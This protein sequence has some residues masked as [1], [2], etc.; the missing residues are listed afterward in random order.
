MMKNKNKLVW[1]ENRYIVEY[2][3]ATPAIIQ[4]TPITQT[5]NLNIKNSTLDSS[6]FF[7]FTIPIP[8]IRT[9][10][11]MIS[12]IP[13]NTIIIPKTILVN[14]P[15]F[16]N[17]IKY[18]NFTNSEQTVENLF[19]PDEIPIPTFLSSDFTTIK[20]PDTTLYIPPKPSP[21]PTY[22]PSPK[23]GDEAYRSDPTTEKYIEKK[24]EK[25]K[26]TKSQAAKE[27][28]KRRYKEVYG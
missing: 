23:Y 11:N 24:V 6:C 1:V 25:R 27:E 7:I 10:S 9:L 15:K 12:T 26:R 14:I 8:L 20:I 13:I 5:I 18:I 2:N 22:T 28:W 19:I 17:L 21:I 16:K 3:L 4:E